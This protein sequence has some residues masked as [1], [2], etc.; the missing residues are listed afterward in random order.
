MSDLA[1]SVKSR[2]AGKTAIVTGASQGIGA[3]IAER[4]HREGA[5][6]VLVSRGDGSGELAERLGDGV[7][8]VRGDIGDPATADAAVEA[9][10]ALGGV[11]VLVNNAGHELVGDVTETDES[12][13]RR[14]FETNAFGALWMLQRAARQMQS[15][16]R[17]GAVVNVGSRLASIG[18]PGLVVYGASKGA[19]LALTRGAAVEPAPDRIRVNFVAPGM[20]VSPMLDSYLAEHP[21]PAATRREIEASIPQGRIG[22]TEEVAAAVAF[23]AADEAIHTTGISLPCDGGYTAA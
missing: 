6:L 15:H 16:A 22:L 14:T 9:A 11:D 7:E 19:M 2:F 20:T 10:A 12:G 23:L 13:A 1:N 18:I 8:V 3:S 5:R 21:D 17:G 4:L